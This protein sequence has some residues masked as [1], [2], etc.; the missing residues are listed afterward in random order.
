MTDDMICVGSMGGAFG[1]RGDV[2]IKSFCAEP[3][4]IADY[5][6]LHL[7]D[8]REITLTLIG[9]IKTGY[10]ARV[11]GVKTKEQADAL[12]GAKLFVPRE[13]LPALPDDEFYYTDLVGLDVVDTGGALLGQVKSVQD[14]G[15]GDL[16]EV[17]GPGLKT[18]VLVPFTKQA[19]PTVD[20]NAR[21]IVVDP[22]EGLF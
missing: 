10:S 16:L 9:P 2:R 19:V 4:D 15:A 17:H 1:I 3:S 8:G 22:P 7:D 20:L 11:S 13:R 5:N 21:R 14:H 6:P 18:S 12:N